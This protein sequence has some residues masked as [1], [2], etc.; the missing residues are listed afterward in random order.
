[1][2][3]NSAVSGAAEATETIAQTRAEARQ[4]DVQAKLKL[5]QI[6]KL[7]GQAPAA[8]VAKAAVESAHGVESPA[9][10]PSVP[11]PPAGAVLNVKQ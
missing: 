1:M 10:S 9:A 3:V 2:N 5:A 6:L 8:G 7:Q 4:G 11:P